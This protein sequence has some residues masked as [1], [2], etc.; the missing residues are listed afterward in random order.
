MEIVYDS[1]FVSDQ[2]FPIH[3]FMTIVLH[4]SY[5]KVLKVKK[6]IDFQITKLRVILYY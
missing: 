3:E 4:G 5:S 2:L 1:S 6:Q